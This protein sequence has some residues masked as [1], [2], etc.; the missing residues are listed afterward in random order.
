M[1]TTRTHNG[2]TD[3]ARAAAD[4]ATDETRSKVDQVKGAVS[5][6]VDRVPEV[7]DSARTGAERAAASL[8]DAAERARLGVEE[9]TTRLQSFPD[10]TLKLVAAGSIGFA[11][12][13]QLAGA[14]RL[15]ILAAI[16]PA[17]LAGGA[18]ATRSR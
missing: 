17:L 15:V 3:E 2:L 16:A 5:G 11:A 8:P 1:T 6:A 12:G 7:L 14:P 4:D 10:S 18:I 13:L 9:T